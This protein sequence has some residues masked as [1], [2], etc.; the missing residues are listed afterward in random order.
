MA[1]IEGF[2]HEGALPDQQVEAC[3]QQHPAA[4]VEL[5]ELLAV[6]GLYGLVPTIPTAPRHLDSATHRRTPFSQPEA[7]HDEEPSLLKPQPL[8]TV[9][10]WGE[11][12]SEWGVE[13]AQAQEEERITNEGRRQPYLRGWRTQPTA[14]ETAAAVAVLQNDKRHGKAKRRS[15]YDY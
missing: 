9:D 11:P 1:N 4:Q 5:D 3:Y 13:R 10:R 15:A 14:E 8:P 2:I 7:A 12:L 6:S